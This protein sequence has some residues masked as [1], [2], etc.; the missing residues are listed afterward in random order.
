M[1][2]ATVIGI[3]LGFGLIVGAISLNTSIMSF[4]DAASVAIVLGGTMAAA[5]VAF[6]LG[7]VFKIMGVVKKAFFTRPVDP[8]EHVGALVKLAEA[9]RRDGILSL[10]SHLSEGQH[11][12]FLSRGLRMAIDGQDPSVIEAAL[13]QEVETIMERHGNGKALF[14]SIG[15]Y[16]PAFGM[17][18]T[19]IG[20]VCMLQQMDD[21]DKLGP[22]MAVALITTFYG[23]LIANLFA[24]PIADKLAVRSTQELGAK[25]LII[26]G[27]M[28]IQAG[29][30]PRVVQQKLMAFLDNRQRQLSETRSE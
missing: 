10:E 14:D 6:P 15:K 22:A 18:G 26:R 25:L 24:M 1:D 16:A 28:S 4:V 27:V 13:E 5:L 23:A 2:I 17:I 30:N 11:D 3:V 20:L 21:P 29:D 19:L 7:Q 9:A 8:V 12:E